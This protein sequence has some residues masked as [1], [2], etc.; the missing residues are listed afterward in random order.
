MNSGFHVNVITLQNLPNIS[1]KILLIKKVWFPGLKS[2]P[3]H[4]I[5]EKLFGGKGFGAMITF[6]FDGKDKNEKREQKR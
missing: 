1:I 4:L 3:T 5:A 2:H 6:D